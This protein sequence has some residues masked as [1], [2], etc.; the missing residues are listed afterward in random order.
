MTGSRVKQ[1]LCAAAFGALVVPAM[2][3]WV[4]PNPPVLG[5]DDYP[6][7]ATDDP[8]DAAKTPKPPK[9]TPSNQATG[10]PQT[11]TPG[12]DQGP[13]VQ[14]YVPPPKDLTGPV[15]VG[16]LGTPEGSPVGT[17]DS[18]NGGFGDRLWS[19]SDRAN[20]EK[21]LAKAP[22][23]SGD[24]VLRDLVRRAVLTRAAAPPGQAKKA[25]VT[26][27]IERLLDAGLIQEAGALAAEAQV[28]NDDGFARV[29]AE[30][31]LLANRAQDA[32]GPA[33]AARQ[34]GDDT[35][36]MQLRAYC[37]EVTGDTA[38]A[39]LTHQVMKA[40]GR[41]DPAYDTLVESV[42]TKKPLAPGAI[43]KPTAMHIF[44]LQQAGLPVTE[45]LARTMGTPENLLAMRDTRNP[46][47][48]RF[49]AAER[50]V[51]T[52]AVSPAELI[53]VA[54]AQDLPLGKV[55]SAAGEAPNLP[56]FMGQVLLRR[57]ATI[58]TRPGAKAE[59]AM[60]ALSLGEKYKL[61]RL[62]SALQADV[63]ASI[64]PGPGLHAYA[65]PFARALV[66]AGKPEAAAA[67][68]TGDPVMKVLVAFASNNPQRIAAT[69]A[70]LKAFA[71]GLAK[72]PPD[73]DQDRAYKALA[74]G[75]LDIVNYPLPPEAKAAA[76]QAQSGTWDG[77]HPGPGQMRTMVE[78]AGTPERRGE[79]ILMLTGL[80]HSYGLKDLAPDATIT[81]VR[82]LREMNEDKAANALA[83][84][85]LAE[86]VPPPPPPQAPAP[87]AS[88]R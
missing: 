36:W 44:L 53:K 19:G 71:I 4:D 75:L 62:A 10:A 18:S 61:S 20:A 12:A 64:K 82:L 2:A 27:R 46:P 79:A 70:D 14:P 85:A 24:K 80:V 59:L 9:Q 5:P 81:F 67:W 65:R 50:I 48:A 45:T 87:Q 56:F 29:Q 51:S 28:P 58:E 73:P 38:T 25:F 8:P 17:L 43:T 23:V 78:I 76:V 31:V 60:T 39:E 77:V 40:Q 3:Q 26:M 72:N 33:T 88:A 86:Y 11:L 16:S 55:A 68:T 49:E 74:L 7:V 6:P 57:A 37:A 52:G 41:N 63:I 32:C 66:L 1:F 34:N 22:L 54:D 84:E 15:E 47:R 30:A 83:V 21:L 69:Q 13:V 42:L 35:F